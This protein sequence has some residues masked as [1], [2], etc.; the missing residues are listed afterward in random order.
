MRANGTASPDAATN[1]C[2]AAAGA[3]RARRCRSAT[4]RTSTTAVC[5]SGMP[6]TLPVIMAWT[7]CSDPDRCEPRAG[8]KTPTGSTTAGSGP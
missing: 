1:P 8:P 2:P 7:S 5:G 6:G 3:V 4:P